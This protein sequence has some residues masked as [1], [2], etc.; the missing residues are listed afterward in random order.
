MPYLQPL[1]HHKPQRTR[2]SEYDDMHW[3]IAKAMFAGAAVAAA[4]VATYFAL[5]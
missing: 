4:I 5:I 1:P 3:H 2:M